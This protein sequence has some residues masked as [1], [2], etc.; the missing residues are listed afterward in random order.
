[1][2]LMKQNNVSWNF[3]FSQSL[4]QLITVN[5]QY[6]GIKLKKQSSDVN[7][8]K[9]V[10]IWSWPGPYYA[11]F[12]VNMGTYFASL[13]IQSKCGKKVRTEKKLRR[14]TLF[15]QWSGFV[16]HKLKFYFMSTLRDK[17][18]SLV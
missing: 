5:L 15:T 1:M 10:C 17:F 9:S 2:V 12:C 4:S 6:N 13:D 8:V 14:R 11:T 18:I 3:M 16:V 7:C